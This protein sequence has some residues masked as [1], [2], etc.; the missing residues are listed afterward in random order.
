M[1]SSD[2]TSSINV[3]TFEKSNKETDNSPQINYSENHL[4][5][6]DDTINTTGDDNKYQSGKNLN[7]VKMET[8]QEVE[9]K[10][11]LPIGDT[12]KNLIGK[13]IYLTRLI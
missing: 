9:S 3:Y 5:I 1:K 11:E 6:E 2:K 13:F 7:S 12:P 10:L 8:V 4:I